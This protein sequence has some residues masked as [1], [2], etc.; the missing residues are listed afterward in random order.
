MTGT[1]TRTA[2]KRPLGAHMSVSGGF[3]TAVK[4]SVAAGADAVQIFTKSQLRWAAPPI[5]PGDAAA[6][7]A[8]VKAAGL[9]FVSAHDSYLINLA[10]GD[11]EVRAKSVASLIHE[12]GRAELL[13]CACVV[14]HPGSPKEDGR[15]VGVE[16]VAAGLRDVLKATASCTCRIALENTAGQ[17][18]TLG[19]TFAE[20]AAMIRLAGDDPR[21]GVCLDTCHAFAAGYELR[22]PAAVAKLAEEFD[23]TLGLKRLLMLH[24]NDSKKDLSSHVDR[25]E[26]I[27]TGCIG[28][29]GFRCVLNEP[30]LKGIPGILE[31]PKDEDDPD[32][33]D[34]RRNLAKLR[35]CEG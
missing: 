27:G 35:A 6:F 4:Q 24:L 18:N 25:H 22:T 13:G 34:D 17:G 32:M 30:A 29:E 31:T 15:D 26:H 14:L 5:Q 20:I 28:E 7:R 1:D 8:A 33:T 19:R 9:R 11:D 12:A 16:R 21:L 3:V 2:A 10:A 23:R